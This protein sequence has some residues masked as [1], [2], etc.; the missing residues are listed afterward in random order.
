ML[1]FYLQCAG[2]KR[3]VFDVLVDYLVPKF[4]DFQPGANM[5]ADGYPPSRVL[6]KNRLPRNSYRSAAL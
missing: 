5:F 2:Q 4:A 1:V 3:Q 6:Q